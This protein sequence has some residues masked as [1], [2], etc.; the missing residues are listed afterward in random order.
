MPMILSL[1]DDD[2]T[3]MLAPELTH[4]LD[5]GV[6]EKTREIFISDDIDEDFGGW[7]T[8]VLRRL[9]LLGPGE[10]ITVWLNCP[11]GDVQSMFVF[12]DLVTTIP[13][14]ITV[15]G[16]GGVCSAAVLMLACADKRLVSEN[17]VLMSHEP[18]VSGEEL[19]YSEAKQRRQWTDWIHKRWIELMARH[20][21]QDEAFWKRTTERTAEYW[22]LGGEDIVA[23]GLA[24]GIFKK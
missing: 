19:R 4:L 13:E 8:M 9:Q 6:F 7:I 1:G 15:I 5:L 11:G 14:E 2:E 21:P 16:I 23:A 22:K 12:Y 24:D 3:P 10:P 20:T 18:V 17:C